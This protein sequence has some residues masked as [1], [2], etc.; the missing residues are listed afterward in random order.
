[1]IDGLYDDF[2]DAMATLAGG[3]CVITTL[4]HAGNPFGFTATAVTSI[5]LGPPLLVVCVAKNT[6]LHEP[7][8]VCDF[9]TVNVLAAEQRELAA[10]FSAPVADQ[11]TDAG[12]EP[13]LRRTPRHP[14]ALA[15]LECWRTET[16]GARDRSVLLAEVVL[17]RTQ[18]RTPLM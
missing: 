9:L 5:S 17:A 13:G 4:D 11:F 7:F 3:V 6:R 2:G 14:A 10:R 12:F 18:P 15:C 16:V 8:A 1:V